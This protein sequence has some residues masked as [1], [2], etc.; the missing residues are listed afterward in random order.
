MLKTFNFYNLY[1]LF[2]ICL[3]SSSCTVLQWRHSDLEIQEK[4]KD[5]SV[6]TDISYFNVDSLN[7]KVR[8]QAVKPNNKKVNLVFLH[9]S[10]SSLSAWDGYLLD[11]TLAASANMYAIDRPGY[12][13]SNFGEEMTSINIS[14][15]IMSSLINNEKLDNVII[16]GSSYGGALAARIGYLNPNIKAVVMISPAIDPAIEKDI[17]GSRFT[18]WKLTRWLVPTAYRV[19]GDEKN[20]HANELELIK[21]DWKTIDVPVLHIH[22]NADDLVPYENINF[23]TKHFRDIQIITIPEKGH[24]IAWKHPDL[25]IPYLHKLIDNVEKSN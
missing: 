19:A 21:A 7:L 15:Q 17:W 14:A 12:G 1:L 16:I 18:Q 23:S 25:I 8:I 10:P 20:V 2:I 11:S 5:S 9:G 13:Y 4:F 6:V 24:E 22:G 3:F